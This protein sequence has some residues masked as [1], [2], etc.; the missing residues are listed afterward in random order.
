MGAALYLV[1]RAAASRLGI[2]VPSW[3]SLSWEE[4]LEWED[5]ANEQDARDRVKEHHRAD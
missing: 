4:H 1:H 5:R 2:E 3:D